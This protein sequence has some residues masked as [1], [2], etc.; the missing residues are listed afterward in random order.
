MKT[1]T[2]DNL[3]NTQMKICDIVIKNKFSLYYYRFKNVQI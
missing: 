3:H 2:L 1:S